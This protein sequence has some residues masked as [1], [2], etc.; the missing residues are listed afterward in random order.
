[1]QRSLDHHGIAWKEISYHNLKEFIQ[2]KNDEEFL[3]L[4]EGDLQTPKIIQKE[5]REKDAQITSPQNTSEN[6]PALFIPILGPWIDE[7][8]VFFKG[9]DKL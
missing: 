9:K 7:A 8:F 4:F 3:N 2:Q 6:I 1:M 5:T